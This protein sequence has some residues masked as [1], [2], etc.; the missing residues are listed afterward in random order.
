MPVKSFIAFD[1]LTAEEMNNLLSTK[2]TR[3][4]IYNSSFDVYQRGSVTTSAGYTL[5]RWYTSAS[6]GSN[7]VT[8]DASVLAPDARYSAKV[9]AGGTATIALRQALETADV[10]HLADKTVTLSAYIASSGPTTNLNMVLEYS[11][12]VDNAVNGTWVA[13]DTAT[14]QA[15]STTMTLIS[16][17]YLVPATAKSLR[18]TF[19]TASTFSAT[20]SFYVG[21]VQ[22]E[23]GN[24]VSPFTRMGRTY[25]DELQLCQ[26]YYQRIVTS[27]NLPWAFGHA[28][29][30]TEVR[31][32]IPMPIGMRTDPTLTVSS[33]PTVANGTFSAFVST[34]LAQSSN[35][36][37]IRITTTGSTSASPA[38][39]YG[40]GTYELS[41]EL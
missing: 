24:F 26:R 14:S 36:A 39:I 11:T 32:A 41:A 34:T 40:S 4:F 17:S 38:A 30:S 6:S 23:Q 9:T 5:D 3:N 1:K 7:T 20:Q 21:N 10:Y 31:V 13:I 28:Q 19:I 18:V 35:Y 33:N 37:W 29:S 12:T 8:Q 22:L 16:A 2:I 27:I 25:A 15:L